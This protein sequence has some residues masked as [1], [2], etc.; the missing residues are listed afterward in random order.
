MHFGGGGL[1]SVVRGSNGSPVEQKSHSLQ[2]KME[3]FGKRIHIL[4][5]GCHL[6]VV[7]KRDGMLVDWRI[8]S[9]A[10]VEQ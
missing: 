6:V 10:K 7:T 9:S 3:D 8:M 5:D 1:T 2:Q 4:G